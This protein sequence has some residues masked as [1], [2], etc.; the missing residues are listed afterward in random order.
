VL[1]CAEA[2]GS[3]LRL[4]AGGGIVAGSDPAA[5]P[6]VAGRCRVG[7]A[8]A[9]RRAPVGWPAQRVE[10]ARASAVSFD[11]GPRDGIVAVTLAG[12][13]RAVTEIDGLTFRFAS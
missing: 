13:Y 11:P 10:R 9:R 12:G 2:L 3:S 4:F 1:R 7:G 5:E 8:T 6:A